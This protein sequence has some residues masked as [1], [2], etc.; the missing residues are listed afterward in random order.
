[1]K[2]VYVSIGIY[3]ADYVINLCIFRFVKL[4][5]GDAE[6]LFNKLL[7]EISYFIYLQ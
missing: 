4:E 3:I 7:Y 1:M 5:N 2:S 6:T